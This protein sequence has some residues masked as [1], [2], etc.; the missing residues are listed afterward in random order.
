MGLLV[1]ETVASLCPA[2]DLALTGL[3]LLLGVASKIFPGFCFVFKIILF[4][5]NLHP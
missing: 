1:P 4:L 5:S 2:A 3:T